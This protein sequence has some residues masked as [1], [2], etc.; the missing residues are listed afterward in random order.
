[1]RAR[2]FDENNI[3]DDGL[4]RGKDSPEECEH[5]A[6]YGEVII[7]ISPLKI[8]P[9]LISVVEGLLLAERETYAKPTPATTG[10]RDNIFF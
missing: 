3:R 6:K 1:M 8:D 7:T 9:Q 5:K 2:R 4:H 10:T